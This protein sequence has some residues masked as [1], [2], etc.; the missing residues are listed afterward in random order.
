[1]MKWNVMLAATHS[2]MQSDK[3]EQKKGLMMIKLLMEQLI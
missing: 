3:W 2:I 1:M